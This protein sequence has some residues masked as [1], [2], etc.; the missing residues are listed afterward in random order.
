MN[1]D[2]SS[3][4]RVDD[5]PKSVTSLGMIAEPPASQQCI[6]DALVNK[7]AETSKPQ[8]PPVK[9][10]MLSS[11]AGG[12]LPAGTA[13]T[14]MRTTFSRPLPSWTLGGETK[15][16][17]SRTNLNQ[18]APLC[19]REILKTKSRQTLVFEPD[20]CSGR[21]RGC[22]FLGGWRAL[23]CGEIFVWT[24]DDIQGWS[25]FRRWRT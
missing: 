18:L 14:A 1:E 22:P 24:S 11:A 10:R 4:R 25:V 3:E 23:L 9:V 15:E 19:C 7:S 6:K 5:G 16:R 13:S 12:L 17:S 21:L 8:L 2:S 20:D